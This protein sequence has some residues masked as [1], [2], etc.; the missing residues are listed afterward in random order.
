MR[1]TKCELEIGISVSI[2]MSFSHRQEIQESQKRDVGG[3]GRRSEQRQ[4]SNVPSEGFY[5]STSP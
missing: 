3:E 1:N 5:T 4:A 2:S